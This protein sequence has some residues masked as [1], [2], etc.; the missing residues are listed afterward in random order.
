MSQK[1]SKKVLLAVLVTVLVLAAAWY[2]RSQNQK[3]CISYYGKDGKTLLY[4]ECP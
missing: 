1:L 3:N 2:Y 4:K